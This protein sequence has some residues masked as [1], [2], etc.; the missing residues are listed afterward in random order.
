[1]E[2]KRYPITVESFHYDLVKQGTSEERFTGSHA[3]DSVV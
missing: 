3:S 2:A 1:M